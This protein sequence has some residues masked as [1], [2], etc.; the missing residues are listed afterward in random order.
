MLQSRA[1]SVY[2]G[3]TQATGNDR[4]YAS[5][6]SPGKGDFMFRLLRALFVSLTLFAPALT[7]AA[8]ESRRGVPG[9]VGP[10]APGGPRPQPLSFEDSRGYAARAAVVARQLQPGSLSLNRTP[11]GQR[12]SLSLMFLG[13]PVAR[14]VVGRG[15]SFAERPAVPLLADALSLPVLSFA[16]RQAL[17]QQVGAL[18][19][20]GLAQAAGRQ[21]RVALLWNGAAVGELRF[22]RATGILLAEPPDRDRGRG[23]GPERGMPKSPDMKLPGPGSPGSGSPEPSGK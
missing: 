6:S 8:P 2:S 17:S 14:V 16:E 13:R 22:D 21:V 10:P 1:E 23:G 11:Q 4:L 18:L 7:Q 5:R 12:L 19:T 3:Q 20:S 15:L 9:P